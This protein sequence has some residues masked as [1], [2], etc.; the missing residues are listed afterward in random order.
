MNRARCISRTALVL[1][2]YGCVHRVPAPAAVSGSVLYEGGTPVV[3]A[4]VWVLDN[5]TARMV[6]T[7]EGGHFRLDSL[8]P[9]ATSIEVVC[10]T[11]FGS[12]AAPT[13]VRRSV[14]LQGGTSNEFSPVL[15]AHACQPVPARATHVHWR[16][17]YSAGFEESSFHPCNSDSLAA[18]VLSYGH[19]FGRSAW[20]RIATN[21][22]N[23]RKTSELALDPRSR[24][25]TGFVEWSGRL[26]GPSASGHM[27]MANYELV[28][29]SVFAAAPSGSCGKE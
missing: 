19:P 29:D 6:R 8:V 9:G 14:V 16:G 3:G 1:V 12:L 13:P 21:A 2:L 11:S 5:R 18:E 28:V 10:P 24:Y 26:T 15:G 7:D 17:F 27:G 4:L 25:S 20:V 23:A 22:W